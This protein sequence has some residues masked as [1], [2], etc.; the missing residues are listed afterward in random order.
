MVRIVENSGYEDDFTFRA[1]SPLRYRSK[2]T[3][4]I[5]AGAML[6]IFILSLLFF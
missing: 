4:N 2:S 6:A 3:P 1:P 5:K